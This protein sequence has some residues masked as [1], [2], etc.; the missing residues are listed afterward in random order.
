MIGKSSSK[1]GQEHD[2][3][4]EQHAQLF[5]HRYAQ[6]QQTK[7]GQHT[8]GMGHRGSKGI[9]TEHI[10][11]EIW[12][13]CSAPKVRSQA[14]LVNVRPGNTVQQGQGCWRDKAGDRG[15]RAK[16]RNRVCCC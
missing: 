6:C 11:M 8:Y 13:E 5:R 9:H 16:G 14:E 4:V 7:I 3:K 10:D 2:W 12:G 1:V 15:K